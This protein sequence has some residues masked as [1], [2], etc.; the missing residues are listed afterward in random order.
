MSGDLRRAA[1]AAAAEA[2]MMMMMMDGDD[3]TADNASLGRNG[4]SGNDDDADDD[5]AACGGGSVVEKRSCDDDDDDDDE[6]DAFAIDGVGG[7]LRRKPPV[8]VESSVDD[9]GIPDHDVLLLGRGPLVHNHP[10]NRWLRDRIQEQKGE[11]DKAA[12]SKKE[13]LAVASEIVRQIATRNPPG[14]FLEPTQEDQQ[15]EGRPSRSSEHWVAV[16]EQQ[17]IDKV[18]QALRAS[19]KPPPSK[20]DPKFVYVDIRE[21]DVLLGRGTNGMQRS[22]V[23]AERCPLP[24]CASYHIQTLDSCF[25]AAGAH[26]S[27]PANLAFRKL[28]DARKAD[29]ARAG[30]GQDKQRIASELIAAWTL[31]DHR[32]PPGRFVMRSDPPEPS[33]REMPTEQV[34]QFISRFMHRPGPSK[35]WTWLDDKAG[36]G[37]EEGA[38]T[39]PSTPQVPISI[40]RT[41]KASRRMTSPSRPAAVL[42]PWF[43]ARGSESGR[44]A[45]AKSSRRRRK[46]RRTATRIGHLRPTGG[47]CRRTTLVLARM[48]RESAFARQRLRRRRGRR[49]Q[50]QN[51]TQVSPLPLRWRG[52]RDTLRCRQKRRRR[53]IM[54][55]HRT[56]TGTSQSH[57]D[58]DDVC[59]KDQRRWKVLT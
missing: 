51:G 39:P 37:E 8:E 56:P 12:S 47:R 45:T 32:D 11:Y 16:G 42:R 43:R 52:W 40:P 27:R 46:G 21:N 29:Y 31:A 6:D 28:M 49:R 36:S 38:P 13:R 50:Q 26:G 14:R 19:A 3:G 17:A 55:G 57:T 9:E 20:P 23:G 7:A 59:R 58:G 24:A 53:S 18:H 35:P 25:F 1:T 5:G 4:S 41:T 54:S 15:Q 22:K 48:G 30:T 33:Y 44:T 2:P 34:K 10:G